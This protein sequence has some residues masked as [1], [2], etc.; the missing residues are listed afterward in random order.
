M[1]FSSTIQR[2]SHVTL[3]GSFA[4]GIV[5]LTPHPAGSLPNTGRHTLAANHETAHDI[6]FAG[7]DSLPEEIKEEK[8]H[9]HRDNEFIENDG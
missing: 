3:S 9:E 6:F 5:L 1:T 7:R 4:L 8:K 2:I